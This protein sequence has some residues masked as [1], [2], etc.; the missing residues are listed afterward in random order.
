LRLGGGFLNRRL[1]VLLMD[2]RIPGK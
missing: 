2:E 1:K